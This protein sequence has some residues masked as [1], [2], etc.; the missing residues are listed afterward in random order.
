VVPRQSEGQATP[1]PPAALNARGLSQKTEK[2]SSVANTATAKPPSP[3]TSPSPVRPS[4]TPYSYQPAKSSTPV[5]SLGSQPAVSSSREANSQNDSRTRVVREWMS[6]H[7]ALLGALVALGGLLLLAAVFYRRRKSMAKRKRVKEPRVQPTYSPNFALRD[8]LA[9]DALVS[10]ASRQPLK[11]VS[12]AGSP[13]PSSQV[14]DEYKLRPA[15]RE[16]PA[17]AAPNVSASASPTGG[18]ENIGR[19]KPLPEPA[20]AGSLPSPVPPNYA[21]VPSRPSISSP[22]SVYDQIASEDQDREVFEL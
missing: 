1:K 14:V 18:L 12:N 19:I 4:P 7:R 9:A 10:P 13:A 21:S 22:A 2:S 8:S 16:T 11:A 3:S 15:Q 17:P 20:M 6:A 5:V